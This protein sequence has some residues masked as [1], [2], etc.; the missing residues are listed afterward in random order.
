VFPF[1]GTPAGL[2]DPLAAL[3]RDG[4]LADVRVE[5][6]AVLTALGAG[7]TWSRDGARI[8]SA[9]HAAL[10]EPAGWTPADAPTALDDEPLR[11]A[12]QA[13]LDGPVGELARSHGGRIELV[14]V[15]DGIVTVR[16]DGACHGCPAAR[17][18]LRQRL[19]NQL[20]RRCPQL[21]TVAEAGTRT[22]ARPEPRPPNRHAA[23][24]RQESAAPRGCANAGSAPARPSRRS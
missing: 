4:T 19:E 12:A 3:L 15:R 2:P 21:R 20:R 5:P 18:T 11:L 9:L 22:A 8:R 13:L 14:D 16:L 17:F 23:E 24:L 6:A 1:T 10:D 7:R